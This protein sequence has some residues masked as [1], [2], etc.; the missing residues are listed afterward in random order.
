LDS[1][2]LIYNIKPSSRPFSSAFFPVTGSPASLHAPFSSPSFSRLK[3][4]CPPSACCCFP[5]EGGHPHSHSYSH[6]CS[7]TG[8]NGTWSLQNK[9][10]AL[11]QH[12]IFRNRQISPIQTKS[13]QCRQISP[14][15][16]KFMEPNRRIHFVWMY[17]S[18]VSGG[19]TSASMIALL[20]YSGVAGTV[21]ARLITAIRP[22][23]HRTRIMG[24]GDHFCCSCSLN[25]PSLF[26]TVS[27][28]GPKSASP[29]MHA[30]GL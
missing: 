10:T 21:V 22:M 25:T 20:L 19:R 14:T 5:P 11:L 3:S 17:L 7:S 30:P 26:I 9:P 16:T 1:F 15:Q 2:K 13:A 18:G 23:F 24:L 29:L 12:G 4:C 27:V 28:L 8:F 6:S